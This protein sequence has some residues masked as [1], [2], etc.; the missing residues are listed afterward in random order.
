MGFRNGDGN[1]EA[2]DV[3]KLELPSDEPE[4]KVNLDDAED[5]DD[6][7][8]DD[9]QEPE[10]KA[11]KG[12]QPRKK[13]GTWAERKKERG[14]D[15]K[16]AKAWE[17]ER[18]DYDRRFKRMQEDSDRNVR[19][20]REE[21]DRMRSGQQGQQR[22]PLDAKLDDIASQIEKELSLIESDPNRGYKD[23]NKLRR[24]EQRLISTQAIMQHAAA[25]MR[26]QQGQPRDPYA[27]RRPIIESE[28]PWVADDQYRELAQRARAYR[29]YLINV[30]DDRGRR[31][32]TIDTDREAL[33]YVQAHFGPEYGMRP[34]PA[35]PSQ[36]VRGIYAPPPSRGLPNRQPAPREVDLGAMGIGHG[37]TPKILA[38]AVADGVGNDD[39]R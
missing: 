18:A 10:P 5:K 20:L 34:P 33:S 21:I 13:N 3:E 25:T 8:D 37:L 2:T 26:Q 31:A 1:E 6:D 24:E 14:Q 7:R 30:G 16:A 4:T 39:D 36:R 11:A 12:D 32:D 15:R 17:A 27:A 35:P 23:Y 9:D 19:Q 22:D 29:E 38:R 28:Y